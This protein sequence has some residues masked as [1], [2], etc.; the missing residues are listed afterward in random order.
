[1]YLGPADSSKLL[2]E[3]SV[4]EEVFDTPVDEIFQADPTIT[5]IHGVKT[6]V[7]QLSNDAQF[8]ITIGNEDP[9]VVTVRAADGTVLGFSNDQ[10]ATG[11]LDAG[12][13][14][15][16]TLAVRGSSGTR[17]LPLHQRVPATREPETCTL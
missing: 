10:S 14:L 8:E 9:V 7:G 1:V 11:V 5:G 6:I 12:T 2:N 4:L 16:Q 15:E 13:G 3:D 17:V